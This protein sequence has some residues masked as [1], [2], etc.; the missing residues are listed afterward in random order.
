MEA[1]NVKAELKSCD[2]ATWPFLRAS[3]NFFDV[4]FSDFSAM[5]FYIPLIMKEEKH[6]AIEDNVIAPFSSH[7]TS[8]FN[9]TS[10]AKFF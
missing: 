10:G 1:M 6:I 9:T 5:Y 3:R 4:A 8:F 7:F 2:F